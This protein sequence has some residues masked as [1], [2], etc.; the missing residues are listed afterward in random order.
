MCFINIR[1]E[2]SFNIYDDVFDKI[3]E[4]H[5]HETGLLDVETLDDK[6]QVPMGDRLHDN[7]NE[8]LNEIT[9]NPGHGKTKWKKKA[10]QNTT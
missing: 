6:N 4:T 8:M 2:E 1:Y 10:E 3:T 7:A 9:N 5:P